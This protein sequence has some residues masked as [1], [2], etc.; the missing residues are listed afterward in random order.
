MYALPLPDPDGDLAELRSFVN[1]T[2][3][4]D[5]RLLVAW[6]LFAWRADRPWPA[7]VLRG[8]Q[9]SANSTTGRMLR[10]RRVLP[11]GH[12]RRL[13]NPRTLVGWRG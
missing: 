11:A 10:A 5:W 4:A 6:L 2:S 1:V 13:R 9:G 8:E 3:E 12:W 7:L